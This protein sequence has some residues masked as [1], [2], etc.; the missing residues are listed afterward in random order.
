MV[1]ISDLDNNSNKYSWN[2]HMKPEFVSSDG[3]QSE[4]PVSWKWIDSI[5]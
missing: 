5:I 2:Q 1:D 3:Y 4:A